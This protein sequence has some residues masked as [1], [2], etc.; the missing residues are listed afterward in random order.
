MATYKDTKT[1]L[2]INHV[3]EE[4]IQSL[5]SSQISPNQIWVT[6]DDGVS[7]NTP[8]TYKLVKD[9]EYKTLNE[10]EV[11][12][13]F[14]D[15]E[16]SESKIRDLALIT[17]LFL[18]RSIDLNE[19]TNEKDLALNYNPD[20]ISFPNGSNLIGDT[21]IGSY[22]LSDIALMTTSP[23][24]EEIINSELVWDSIW[25]I[26]TKDTYS[27]IRSE[28]NYT[29]LVNE[30]YTNKIKFGNGFQINLRKVELSNST[31]EEAQQYIMLQI[32][33]P[34]G[35][36]RTFLF[37]KAGY[38]TDDIC[39]VLF[40]THK[41]D[42]QN[43]LHYFKN[44][45]DSTKERITE[46]ETSALT[47][48][49]LPTTYSTEETNTNVILSTLDGKE[50]Y[51]VTYTTNI[52][53]IDNTT[54]DE[55]LTDNNSAIKDYVDAQ[56]QA[57]NTSLTNYTN[58]T[59]AE[60]KAALINQ[61]LGE[62]AHEDLNTI[63]ELSDALHDNKD[64]IDVLNESIGRKANQSDLDSYLPLSAG[65]DKKLTGALYF[66]NNKFIR[67][68]T[69]SSIWENLIGINTSN[70]IELGDIAANIDV[71]AALSFRPAA[72]NATMLG[73][74]E[75]QWRE[76][77]GTTIYQNRKQ[78]A[79]AEDL[80]AVTNAT[81]S[82]D[83]KTLT[84]TKRDGTSFNFQG[85]EVYKGTCSS[86]SSTASKSVTCSGFTLQKG[87]IIDV[88]FTYSS[89]SE[90]GF[91][92]LNVNGTGDKDVIFYEININSAT[93]CRAGAAGDKCMPYGSW[94]AGDTVRF[95]YDGTY[96]VEILNLS[97]GSSY[98]KAYWA[99]KA[100]K[101]DSASTSTTRST[102]DNSTN[103]ATTAFVQTIITNVMNNIDST[104]AKI[105][106]YS[107]EEEA[108]AASQADPNKICVY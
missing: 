105:G 94:N 26:L 54:L 10:N 61:L 87:N 67:S 63:G 19:V 96:W 101:A 6:P 15:S 13:I 2:T 97:K 1:G 52:L 8:L 71:K 108:L 9:L 7:S 68:Y 49:E 17:K 95:Y 83:N 44:E 62:G 64:I 40:I 86:S 84:V 98:A 69:T 18:L 89:G 23:S 39:D 50:V 33:Y 65:S 80:S 72:S 28:T 31:E 41:H 79:N 22:C 57:L 3:T 36:V 58:T 12:D 74:S 29:D 55:A 45:F 104:Y 88:T 90:S 85:E 51:P 91:M 47:Y 99:G 46:L 5:D 38:L 48:S 56:D 76:I 21:W 66:D 24:E 106:T 4:I 60:A 75:S 20:L 30:V 11:G 70:V 42:I 32:K 107:S 102:T 77:Y 82:S 16:L 92:K 37:P 53:T 14:I 35:D 34:V 103:I 25:N 78:V 100:D 81:L 59:V 93:I 73:T 27:A 43:Y